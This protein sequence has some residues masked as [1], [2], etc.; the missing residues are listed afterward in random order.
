MKLRKEENDEI[1]EDSL[2]YKTALKSVIRCEIQNLVNT[3]DIFKIN[4]ICIPFP[5]KYWKRLTVLKNQSLMQIKSLLFFFFHMN[6]MSCRH[7]NMILTPLS[8]TA[9]FVYFRF[10]CQF[11]PF[12]L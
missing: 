7:C 3:C 8:Q 5:Q 9:S 6:F 10:C 4:Y 11:D 2:E 1:L 12:F